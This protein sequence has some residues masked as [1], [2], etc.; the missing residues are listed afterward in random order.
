P[1]GVRIVLISRDEPPPA[2][3]RLCANSRMQSV[4]WDELKFTRAETWAFIRAKGREDAVADGFLNA[5]YDKTEGWAA[6]LVLLLARPEAAAVDPHKLSPEAVFDYF[7]GE[8]FDK[9]EAETREF[10]LKT[11]F[12][13]KMTPLMAEKLTGTGNAGHILSA[14]NRR[15]FFTERLSLDERVYRYHPLFREYLL[16]AAR[17][18]F[19]RQGTVQIQRTAAALLTEAGHGEDALVLLRDAQDW[20]GFIPLVLSQAQSLAT[21]GRSRTLEEWLLSI[22]E[23]MREHVPWVLYWLGVCRLPFSPGESL[24]LFD[25]AFHRFDAQ[26]DAAGA[27]LSWAGAVNT[28]MLDGNDLKPL[29]QWIEWIDQRVHRDPPFPSPEIEM[30]VSSAMTGALVHRQPTHPHIKDWMDRALSLSRLSP[31]INIRIQTC[32][33]S[34]SYYLWMGDQAGC[35]LMV[36]ELEHI[37]QAPAASPLMTIAAKALAPFA[38]NWSG[39][40]YDYSLCLIAEGLEIARESGVH[41]WDYILL[42]Q[43]VYSSLGKGDQAQ[44]GEF[45]RKMEPLFAGA[46]RYFSHVLHLASASYHLYGGDL[47]DAAVHG[48]RAL[49]LAREAGSY[50]GEVLSTLVAARIWLES[51]EFERAGTHLSAAQKRIHQIGSASFE[52]FS[53][54][55]EAEFAFARGGDAE[56]AEVLRR[57]LALEKTQKYLNMLWWWWRPSALARLFAKALDAGI[58]VAYVQGLIRRRGLLPPDVVAAPEAWPW[59]L[60]IRTL[61]SFEILRGGKP[62][63]FSGKVQQKPLAMLKALIVQ[64]GRNVEMDQLMYALWPDSDGD[65]AHKS[66]EITLHRLRKLLGEDKAVRLNEGKLSLDPGYCRVDAWAFE[67]TI[68][69]AD[70]KVRSGEF[71]VRSEKKQKNASKSESRNLQTAIQL[72]EKALALYRGPFLS[73]DTGLHWTVSYR[74]SLRSKFIRLVLRLGAHYMQAEQ[75][76]DAVEC[77]ERGIEV[78]GLAEPFYQ[79]LML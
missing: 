45:L 38:H 53:L 56:G 63:S 52:F 19:P 21:Q 34:L 15:Q 77:Y 75:W 32:V 13:P 3:A 28:F 60:H 5:V 47:S 50:P 58:E 36:K 35:I 70:Q 72:L 25:R 27:L 78:D 22:P 6:G 9:T 29:D 10:L 17:R 67:R 66:C 43:G 23:Q 40:S 59:H 37:A 39:A 42:A 54:M 26:G 79:Q 55:V 71:E 33:F 16:S 49:Q 12:L 7:A 11:A 48:E 68:E 20:S 76:R 44:A 2:L 74:E 1:E 4:G 73:A 61:G 41:V 14:L 18:V 24:A 65:Q 51:D 46:S 31:D 30:Y 62:L 57:A 8:I 69:D 64:G